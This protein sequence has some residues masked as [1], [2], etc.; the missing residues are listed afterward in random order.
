MSQG[1]TARLQVMTCKGREETQ[2]F[3]PVSSR[4]EPVP[5][6]DGRYS[7]WENVVSGSWS[8]IHRGS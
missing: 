5:Q 3:P 4:G 7:V 2:L 1:W 8:P 6:V